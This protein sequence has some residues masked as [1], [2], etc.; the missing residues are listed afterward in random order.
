MSGEISAKLVAIAGATG[1]CGREVVRAA[2]EHGLRVRA[3]VRSEAKLGRMRDICDEVR[4]VQ[5]TQRDT[6][7]GALDGADYLVSA[8]GKTFQKDNVERRSVD[9]DANLY[10]F[11][12]AK[13]AAVARVA[14][15]S[16]FMARPN[17]PVELVRIFRPHVRAK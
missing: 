13:S 10:L 16:V 8:L 11:H 12:E 14:L 7:R 15:V 3:L 9:V 1:N 6:L 2:K 4:V 17:H 5:A